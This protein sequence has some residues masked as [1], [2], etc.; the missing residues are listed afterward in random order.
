MRSRSS[1]AARRTT[2]ASCATSCGAAGERF[3]TSS[4]TE[5]VL[6]GYLRWGEAL[7][8]RLN[9]M[10]AFAIWD[11]RT[12]K[13]VL[14]RDRMGIK[15]LYYYRTADGVLFGSEPKAILAN[16]LARRTVDADGLR[17]LFAFVEDAG[18]RRVV[19]HARGRAGHDRHRRLARA[20]RAPLLAAGDA[21]ARRRHGDDRRPRARAARRHRRAASSSPTC[22]AASC[23]PAGSTPARSPRWPRRCS[24]RRASA[25]AASPSTSW[26]R[27]PTSSRTP[28]PD[29]GRAVRARSRRARRRR[30]R[31]HRDRPPRA[32]RP[33]GAPRGGR[34]TRPSQRHGRH[35]RFA[36][37][38]VQ[39]DPPSIRRSRSPASRRTRSSA[40][41][42]SSTIR[43]CSA[44][45]PSRG[46]PWTIFASTAWTPS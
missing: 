32:G 44:P 1:T 11:G 46:S 21:A 45:A 43:A 14:I 39:G 27:R 15:P 38:V 4:D 2:S 33:R 23:S 5:V 19:G 12:R 10:Y 25:C 18:A 22:R 6:R 17:E 3:T 34:G 7:A 9:G 20:P 28:A 36:V 8:E 35:G 31:G 29:A 41:T 40:A 13:L 24:P 42:G 37:P 26:G 30:A 16:P